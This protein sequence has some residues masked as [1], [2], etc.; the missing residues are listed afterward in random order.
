[1]QFLKITLQP[2]Q[3]WITKISLLGPLHLLKQLTA[4]LNQYYELNII[5]LT[6][7]IDI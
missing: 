7:K 1:M 6:H 5:L 4:Y 2:L 3:T